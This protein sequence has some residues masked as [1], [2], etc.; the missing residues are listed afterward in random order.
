MC[1][2]VK[3]RLRLIMSLVEICGADIQTEAAKLW[4]RGCDGEA[5]SGASPG[6]RSISWLSTV[7]DT[8]QGSLQKIWMFGVSKLIRAAHMDFC[9]E[10]ISCC[11]LLV[12]TELNELI[13]HWSTGTDEWHSW[14]VLA[15]TSTQTLKD[16]HQLVF[17]SL[18]CFLLT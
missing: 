2:K 17:S 15:S 5:G 11:E 14:S 18:L 10:A 7:E 6:W 4:V 12:Y 9:V 8:W 1:E 16:S 3:G 13:K